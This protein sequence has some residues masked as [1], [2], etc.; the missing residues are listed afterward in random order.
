MSE[1]AGKISRRERKRAEIVAVAEKVFFTEGYAGASMAEIAARVGG[2]K[3][4]LYNHFRSKEELLLAVIAAVQARRMPQGAGAPPEE[5]TRDEAAFRAWLRRFGADN[6]ARLT[7]YELLSLQRL[8][9]AEAVR[10]PEVGR[11][12][13][14]G[15]VAPAFAKFS[16]MFAAAMRK[17]LIR[18]APPEQAAEH[19]LELCLGWR[20]RK[21][22]WGLEDPPSADE[23]AAQVETAVAVFMDGYA[24]R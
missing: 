23:I 8:A 5:A 17:G 2:S 9:V 19:F 16:P 24:V 12:C 22:L 6:L 4:T 3:G 14:E 7:S 11:A 1:S 21:V 20:A 13:Y 15:G 18:R 10:M